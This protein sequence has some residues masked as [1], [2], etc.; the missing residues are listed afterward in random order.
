MAMS[1]NDTVTDGSGYILMNANP[2]DESAPYIDVVIRTG[3]NIY[4][5]ENKVRLGDLS[6]LAEEFVGTTPG[7]GLASENVYLSGLIRAEEG[8]IAGWIITGSELYSEVS[9]GGILTS[10]IHLDA[11]DNTIR[12]HSGS[13][14]IRVLEFS[15]DISEDA[16]DPISSFGLYG[17]DSTIFLKRENFVFP[18]LGAKVGFNPYTQSGTRIKPGFLH[19][20]ASGSKTD[21]WQRFA[22]GGSNFTVMSYNQGVPSTEAYDETYGVRIYKQTE[23]SQKGTDQAVNTGLYSY[24][25]VEE[26]GDHAY[27]IYGESGDPYYDNSYAGYFKGKVAVEGNISTT[28]GIYATNDISASGDIYC[29]SLYVDSASVHIGGTVISA[30]GT[31]VNIGTMMLL[32]TQ[33]ASPAV[34]DGRGAIYCDDNFA[35]RIGMDHRETHLR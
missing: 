30:E 35:Y 14:D 26:T 7:Y 12:L 27:A 19:L 6:G 21:D 25:K 31:S 3:S 10:S 20:Q 18:Q 23:A 9:S 5:T 29:K 33:S 15:G 24:V 28:A 32:T 22:E 8:N 4:D 2:N 16:D 11:G 17:Q 13:D 34:P 1:N